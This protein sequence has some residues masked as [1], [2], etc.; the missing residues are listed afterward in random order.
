MS[1][2]ILTTGSPP[3]KRA[4]REAVAVMLRSLATGLAA[5]IPVYRSLDMI[6]KGTPDRQVELACQ[7][8]QNHLLQGRR[9]SLAMRQL[10]HV[11][12]PFQVGLVRVGE[13]SGQLDEVLA[14]LASYE[15]KA[16]RLSLK[17]RSA[18]TYPLLVSAFALALMLL[19]PPL[20]FR[21]LAP[22]L[23][24]QQEIPLVTKIYLAYCKVLCNPLCWLLGAGLT[25]SLSR[26]LRK[27]WADTRLRANFWARLLKTPALGNL[28]RNFAMARFARAFGL[29]A[30]VGIGPLQALA[31]AAEVSGDPVL[32]RDIEGAQKALVSGKTLVRSLQS[33]KYFSKSFLG[34]LSAAE[35]CGTIA[36]DFKRLADFYEMELDTATDAFASVLEPIVMMALGLMAGFMIFAVTMP[37]LKMVQSCL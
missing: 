23:E 22:F 15:E 8:L 34:I 9:F 16:R 30:A 13:N 29:Q 2:A 18:L 21:L 5:G 33:T 4:G 10:P 11:F 28:L 31:L 7:Q 20:V 6:A 14:E 17:F 25:V 36:E 35:E 1:K 3:Q 37:M 24:G 32:Q 26:R 19:S 27:C 12:T